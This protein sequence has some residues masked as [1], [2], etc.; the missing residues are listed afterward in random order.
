MESKEIDYSLYVLIDWRLLGLSDL[1][2]NDYFDD[3]QYIKDNSLIFRSIR[4]WQKLEEV[5]S[6]GS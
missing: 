3:I 5:G 2:I 1:K 4:S 6:G